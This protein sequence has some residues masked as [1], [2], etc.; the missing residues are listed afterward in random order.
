MRK[1]P[2]AG[3]ASGRRKSPVTAGGRAESEESVGRDVTDSLQTLAGGSDQ[4]ISRG[5]SGFQ[6]L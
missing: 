6:I 5:P 2:H 3:A 1:N 4:I